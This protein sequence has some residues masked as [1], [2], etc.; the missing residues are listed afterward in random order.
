MRA[1]LYALSAML[2][3]SPVL[4][5]E[6]PAADGTEV[7]I[8]HT[9]GHGAILADR[10]GRPLYVREPLQREELFA[11][12]GWNDSDCYDACAE[13]WPPFLASEG[14]PVA[15][16]SAVRQERLGTIQREDGFL[17]VT[18]NG[19]ALYYYA[20]DEGVPRPRGHG[21]TDDWGRWKLLSPRG[22]PLKDSGD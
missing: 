4:A 1:C 22:E 15:A 2:C 11:E 12:A 21:V 17:Q 9:R 7:S 14:E 3:L 6:Q 16:D 19:Y 10:Q 20:E 18:Y 13:M 8:I 5:E